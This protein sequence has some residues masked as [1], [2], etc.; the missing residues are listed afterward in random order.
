MKKLIVLLIILPCIAYTQSNE[1]Y[2]LQNGNSS[3]VYIQQSHGN[4]ILT[5]PDLVAGQN[6]VRDASGNLH[7]AAF[8]YSVGGANNL[9][10]QQEGAYVQNMVEIS[11][12]AG[13]NNTG[14]FE[15]FNG[16]HT[17]KLSEVAISGSND[18]H[19]KQENGA[20]EIY[21][22]RVAKED[23]QIPDAID[24]KMDNPL[25]LP[26]IYQ[27]GY[28]N[29]ICGASPTGD[30]LQPA[31]YNTDLPAIQNSLSGSNWLEIWQTGD[32]NIVGLVQSGFGNNQALINQGNGNNT[33][34][35]V[36][37][38]LF[39]SNNLYVEQN[40]NDDLYLYQNS[41]SGNNNAIIIQH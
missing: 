24:T 18:S 39:G 12:Q 11:Q 31:T 13:G 37:N 27:T 19:L 2:L 5:G 36:Q 7:N 29:I 8:Q 6:L 17:L 3:E 10:V 9:I 32:N 20:G 41:V 33:I 4:N 35:A 22:Q 25:S 40:G 34:A 38:S 30:P 15:Q 14:K 28:N 26:G 16:S 21:L 1:A 23:N